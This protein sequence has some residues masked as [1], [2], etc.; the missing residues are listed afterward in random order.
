MTAK[1]HN[2]WLEYRSKVTGKT[3]EQIREEMRQRSKLADRTNSGFASRTPEERKAISDLGVKA[4]QK[5]KDP[6][7]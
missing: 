1:P 5:K 6:D 3:V 2:L 4:R 7:V